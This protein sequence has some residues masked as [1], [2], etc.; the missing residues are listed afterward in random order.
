MNEM[1]SVC[2]KQARSFLSVTTFTLRNARQIIN[3]LEADKITYESQGFNITDFHG[4]NEF[5]I[6]SPRYYLHT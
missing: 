5:S 2:Q 3:A 1:Y 4:E 6:Q